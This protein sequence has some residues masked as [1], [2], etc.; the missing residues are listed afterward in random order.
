MVFQDAP[1]DGANIDVLLRDTNDRRWLAGPA[2]APP[3]TGATTIATTPKADVGWAKAPMRTRE[4]A[5]LVAQGKSFEQEVCT[6]RLGCS[7]RSSRPE[8]AAPRL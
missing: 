8:A 4:D 6:R 5:E 2:P 3:A 1:R 7:V